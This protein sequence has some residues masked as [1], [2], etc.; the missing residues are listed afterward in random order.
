MKLEQDFVISTWIN[1]IEMSLKT[2]DIVSM[3]KDPAE[4]GS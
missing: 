3:V 4:P 2:Y 1:E